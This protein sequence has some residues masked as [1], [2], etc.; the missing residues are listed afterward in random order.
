V[1]GAEPVPERSML[2]D[3]KT[4]IV[5]AFALLIGTTVLAHEYHLMGGIPLLSD[6]PDEMRTRLFPLAGQFD[7]QFDK[8]YIKLLHPFVEFIKYGVFL[9]IIVL[10]Q[11]RA[12]SR[13][14]VFLSVTIVVLGTLVIGAQAARS[15]F[16]T[17]ALTG[18][19][20]YHYLRRR[21]SL[22]KFGAAFLVLFVFLGFFGS[23]R[24]KMSNTGQTYQR[25][26][27]A[28]GFPEGEI[29]DGAAFGYMTLTLSFETFSRL[30]EDLGSMGRPSA[31]YLFYSFHR[32]IPRAN[33]QELANESY[34]IDSMTSTFLGEF[35][36]DYGYWGA[37]LGPLVLGLGYGWAYSR[38]G[39]RNPVYWIYVRAMLIQILFFFPYVNL[40]SFYNTWFLDLFF[41]YF[42][43][44]Y[45][46]K[47][48]NQQLSS[49][50]D[51]G[52]AAYLPA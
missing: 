7:P 45:L 51:Q 6:N 17:I 47:R 13:M 39:G 34:S 33:I 38:G 28:S 46:S 30:T 41:M 19:V 2:P 43:I 27:N 36:A 48:E 29:W 16:V 50:A 15:F 49:P 12:K 10:S 35:Y 37:L 31:G 3:R 5:A 1:D 9:A 22:V 25:A 23:I 18:V 21:I 20:L 42:L 14:T 4:L 24:M 8:L 26:R 44:R 11:R 32:L 52:A 40:F